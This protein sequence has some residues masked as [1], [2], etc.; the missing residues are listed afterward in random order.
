MRRNNSEKIIKFLV[1]NQQLMT[2]KMDSMFFQF[3]KLVYEIHENERKREEHEI[4]KQKKNFKYQLAGY[5]IGGL[6]AL[7]TITNNLFNQYYFDALK[8]GARRELEY[9]ILEV[10]QSVSIVKIIEQK[11]ILEKILIEKNCQNSVDSVNR[12]KHLQINENIELKKAYD[13]LVK[14]YDTGS[15]EFKEIHPFIS[16]PNERN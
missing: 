13:R 16:S 5:I 12:L 6:L 11:M 14:R 3:S 4:K 1:E 15:N 9:W 8:A 2:E 7:T 10:S